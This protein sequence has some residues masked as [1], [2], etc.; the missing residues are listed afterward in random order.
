MRLRVAFCALAA[1]TLSCQLFQGVPPA[2][3]PT[4]TGA[5]ATRA[6]AGDSLQAVKL[7]PIKLRLGA[8]FSAVERK[9]WVPG[10]YAGLEYGLPFDLALAANPE[11]LEGL[12]ADQ[13]AFLIR[14]GFVVMH[15][16]EEQFYAIRDEVSRIHGQ[17]YFLT[18][19]A[20]FHVLHLTFDDLLKALERERLRPRM[21]AITAATL[22]ELDLYLP[23][24]Q[25]TAVEDDALRAA[26]YLSVA[27]SLFDPTWEVAPVVA[28]LVERQVAQ[29]QAYGGLDQSTLFPSFKDD[30]GAYRPVGHYATDPELE[31]YFQGVT[32]LGR[33]HFR[34]AEDQPSRVPLLVTLALRRATIGGRSAVA[35]WG[36]V[37]EV[38]DFLVGPTDDA[39][40]AEYAELMDKVYGGDMLPTDLAD[41]SLWASFVSMSDQLP[42]PQ[43][44]STFVDSLADLEHDAGWRFMGQRFTLDALV[45][46][47][48]V[49]DKVDELNGVRRL[50]PTG[51]DVMGALGS[52]A[53]MEA[54]VALGETGYPGYREQ[55]DIMQRLVE[56]RP[57]EEWHGRAYDAWLFSF[58]PILAEKDSSFPTF[59]RSE[60]WAY[61]DLNAALGNWA[62][63]KHDTILYAKMPEGVGGGGPPCTSDP[64]PG[65]VEPNPEAFYRMA[66]VAQTIAEGLLDRGLVD[67]PEAYWLDTGSFDGLNAGMRVLGRDLLSLGDIAVKELAGRELSRED[68]EVIQRCLGPAECAAHVPTWPMISNDDQ[69]PPP[70]I[71]AAVA[72]GAGNVLE[73]ATGYID[74]IYAIVPLD[75]RLQ[76]AQ[77]G[78]YS[79]YEFVQPRGERLTDEVWREELA[80]PAAPS[81][82]AWASNFVLPGGEPRDVVGFYV[83][84]VFSITP[85]GDRLNLRETPSLS[86][87]VLEH[88]GEGGYVQ[89]IGGPVQADGNTW[90]KFQDC[91]TDVIGWSVQHPDW[92]LRDWQ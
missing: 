11:V 29:V 14:N 4:E 85:E 28:N 41:E 35:E 60:A 47:N 16:Q 50:I 2:L 45:F 65:Y 89:V 20:A 13:R 12:S 69:I 24:L 44:N 39:G 77:G 9:E 10:A 70:P 27:M 6:P 37:Q 51:L 31:A 63:L 8:L 79:Y 48:L 56:D 81:L 84:S 33:V 71:V 58:L 88:L 66:Y 15:S 38:L 5:P 67:D 78:V 18:T 1:A 83:G 40:P 3:A 46:Q 32:W 34:L 22:E 43:I 23:A 87:A 76:V 54:L 19:D 64:T 75:G 17:P 59:M 62:E 92:Y 42:A 53:A 74:R 52:S 21:I 90:W 57:E 7:Q 82:P 91:F 73:V 26:A 30:Y 25:G 68:Y 86:G 36:E 61:K 55:M 49:Y 80:G 72:G